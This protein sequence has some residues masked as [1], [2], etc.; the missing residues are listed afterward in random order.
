[1]RC[2]A[3]L[4]LD[5]YETVQKDLAMTLAAKQAIELEYLEMSAEFDKMHAERRGAS[6]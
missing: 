1:M 6:A 2:E 5:R 3:N 4:S